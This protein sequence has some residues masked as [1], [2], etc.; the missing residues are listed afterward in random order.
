MN[1]NDN[2]IWT[3]AHSVVFH[4]FWTSTRGFS[5]IPVLQASR[6][7][8]QL[9][10]RKS[11]Y[12]TPCRKLALG[13]VFLPS[14]SVFSCQFHSTG[15]LLLGKGQKI[16]II[17]I[18]IT[19]LHKKSQGCCVSVASAAGLFTTKKN[20]YIVGPNEFFLPVHVLFFRIFPCHYYKYFRW[21]L[22]HHC[23]YVKLG[24]HRTVGVSF[25]PLAMYE[26]LI[27][28]ET[29]YSCSWGR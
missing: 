1:I 12:F 14:T 7:T 15:A 17:I 21:H 26:L 29:N 4:T 28:R 5:K 18:V 19:G 22:T 2:E 13:Q 20:M 6:M 24:S 16:T 25:F 23:S 27:F 11:V 3:I 8:R 9:R 10:L